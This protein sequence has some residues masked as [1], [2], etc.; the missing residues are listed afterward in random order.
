MPRVV[1]EKR[2]GVWNN[3]YRFGELEKLRFG[4]A[5]AAMPPYTGLC[6]LW[7]AEGKGR[8]FLRQPLEAN[9]FR[10]DRLFF[11]VKLWQIAGKNRLSALRQISFC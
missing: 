5:A 10:G 1:S 3:D 7:S 9:H 2:H 4:T 6:L 11:G 8:C